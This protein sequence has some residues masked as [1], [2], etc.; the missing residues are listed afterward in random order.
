MPLF[1]YR[2]KTKEGEERDG[3]IDTSSKESA[4]DTLQQS[5]LVVVSLHEDVK[6][7]SWN[8]SIAMGPKQRDIV[9]F[10]REL[11]IFFDAQI[12]IIEALQ[13]LLEE[14]RHPM[15]RAATAEII[16]DVTG[17][18]VLSQAM[19]K[20]SQIFSPLYINLVRSGEESGTL[21]ETFR[22]L[23]D[24]LERTYVLASKARNAMIYPAFILGAFLIVFTLL[25][26]VVIPQLASVFDEFDQETPFL[27]TIIISFSLILRQ[28]AL[29][30]AAL[31]ILGAAGIW[32]WAKSVAGKQFFHYWQLHIPVIGELYRKMYMARFT[33][34]LETLIRGGIPIL[35]ALSITRDIVGNVIYKRAIMD[36]SE[37]VKAGGTISDGL[38]KTRE[39]PALVTQM[40]RVGETSGKLDFI[41]KNIAK[42]YTREVESL[43]ANLITL[44]EPMLILLLGGGVAVIVIAVLTPIY[45]LVSAF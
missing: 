33:D 9:I 41:L 39:V 18:M 16:E 1:K 14:T 24:Y 40:I 11:A 22:Y 44:I 2:A 3:A 21:Q 15:L 8:M 37:S 10:S 42:Y 43:V 35:R 30:V 36:A 38:R 13:T 27:T 6:K 23:A 19:A 34:N 28:W 45:N 32:H 31:A 7:S 20:H 4:L 25:L 26:I 29:V 17:G 12:P 5:G